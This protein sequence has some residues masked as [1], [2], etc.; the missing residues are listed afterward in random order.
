MAMAALWIWFEL[1]R[2]DFRCFR[3]MSERPPG[4]THGTGNH[5]FSSLRWGCTTLLND[6]KRFELPDMLPCS[7]YLNSVSWKLSNM[8]CQPKLWLLDRVLIFLVFIFLVFGSKYPRKVWSYSPF[9]FLLE[10]V[11]KI[12]KHLLRVLWKV[13]WFQNI[14]PKTSSVTVL[15]K[16]TQETK[17]EKRN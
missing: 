7:T 9:S 13:G 1:S 8:S 4:G 16:W 3:D 12:Q 11:F 10:T 14:F 6:P 5:H 2:L 17:K 15:Q